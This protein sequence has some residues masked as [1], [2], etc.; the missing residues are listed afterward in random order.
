MD[1]VA[2]IKN[3]LP[4]P[5]LINKNFLFNFNCHL[6]PKN[7]ISSS[8]TKNGTTTGLQEKIDYFYSIASTLLQIFV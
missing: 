8:K 6:P 4:Y 5:L 2:K 7:K 1:E 3:G